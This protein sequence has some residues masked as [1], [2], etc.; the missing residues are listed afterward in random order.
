M[1]IVA[2]ICTACSETVPLNH[3]E[4]SDCG[5]HPDYAAAVLRDSQK[6]RV[7]GIHVTQVL[8]CPRRTAIEQSVDVAVDPLA[9]NAM[10]GGSAWHKLME[11]ASARPELCEVE[12]A[13]TIN[14][15]R[16]VGVV[17]RLHPPTAISDW[18]TTSDWAEKWLKQPAAQGGGMKRD[19]LAQMS[20]YA[21][22]VEQTQHWRPI[23]GIAWYR[24]Q[25]SIL[26][27]AEK[28]W[29]LQTT[30]AYKPVDG[31]YTVSDLIAQAAGGIS[32][33]DLPLVGE[34]QR[35]GAKSACDY[36]AVRETCWTAA[37][38]ASF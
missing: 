30:L 22:L 25:K 28:L 11:T 14:G 7:E 18:K 31:S 3:F 9:Y 16:I 5:V 32:W 19:H 29:D 4:T 21:E 17:D 2:W 27:F 15:V 1:S 12:V 24:M 6:P 36:C 34:T 38:G 10:L 37:R 13:G 8:G 26:P 23:H 33:S 20:L 35:Y